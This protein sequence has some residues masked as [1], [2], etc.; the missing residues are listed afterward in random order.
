MN[1]VTLSCATLVLT[2]KLRQ[3]NVTLNYTFNHEVQL[4]CSNDQ[5]L[6]QVKLVGYFFGIT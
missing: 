4:R 1:L 2:I 3:R 6:I 5:P